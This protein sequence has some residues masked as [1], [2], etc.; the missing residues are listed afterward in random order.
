MK[1]SQVMDHLLDQ[2]GRYVVVGHTRKDL[3]NWLDTIRKSSSCN[4]DD[5]SI[6]SYMTVKSEMDPGFFF[7]TVFLKMVALV[8]Y[9]G[10]T[11]CRDVTT[12]TLEM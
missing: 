12:D 9:F 4:S 11:R 8:N 5:D 10:P 2:S 6:I 1:T 7:H 3:Q